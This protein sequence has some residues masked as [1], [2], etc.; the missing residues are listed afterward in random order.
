MGWRG[1][2]AEPRV[3]GANGTGV[4]G[5]GAWKRKTSRWG[6]PVSEGGKVAQ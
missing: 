1:M 4:E 5:R 6:P 2:G 3:H